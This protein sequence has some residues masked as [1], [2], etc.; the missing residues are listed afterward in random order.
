MKIGLLIPELKKGGAENV[1]ARLSKKFHEMNI[2]VYVIVFSS[3]T[4]T[5]DFGGE[6]IS[7]E[8]NF[9]GNPFLKLIEIYKRA[10]SLKRIKKEN[11]FDYVI[12]FLPNADI[13]NILSKSTEKTFISVRNHPS[14]SLKGFYGCFYKIVTRQF[15]KRA[16]RIIAVSNVIKKDL[17]QNFQ[18][19]ECKV[20]VIY[21]SYPIDEIIN[22]SNE[23]LEC[24]EELLFRGQTIISVG[25]LTKQKGQLH[26]LR[27]F[28]YL[29]SIS[30][31]IQMILIGDGELKEELNSTINNLGLKQKVHLLGHKSNPYKYLRNAD[32]F[33][34]SSLYEG[35]PNALSEAMICKTPAIS[36]NCESGPYEIMIKNHED[37]IEEK[38][39]NTIV[40]RNGI[41]V[42]PFSSYKINDS[43]TVKEK[44]LANQLKYL[45]N[46]ESLRYKISQNAYN[47]I[48]EFHINNI[49]EQW[50]ELFS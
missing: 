28:K 1:V 36:T 15:Y 17:I 22:L 47:R 35:F 23:P 39:T 3:K 14:K 5:C 24:N 9:Y 12:S 45:L 49:I 48:S 18:I 50:M 10:K 42:P 2:E 32:V 43:D 41:L 26:L 21:N 27:A 4:V 38:H 30:P 11:K 16:D 31:D 25:R 33:V 19:P 20:E 44:E 6:L 29:S 46:N 13:I 7:L 8:S 37:V 34:L 40:T